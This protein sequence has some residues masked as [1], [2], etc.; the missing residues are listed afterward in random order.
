MATGG[1]QIQNPKSREREGYCMELSTVGF[2]HGKDQPK[3]LPSRDKSTEES[4]I[5]CRGEGTQKLFPKQ[6][7]PY[8]KKACLYWGSLHIFIK[9]ITIWGGA[10]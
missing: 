8:V 1:F 2:H 4:F 10:Q 3:Q 9:E 5:P 7:I 6:Y